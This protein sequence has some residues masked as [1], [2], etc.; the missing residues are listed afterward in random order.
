MLIGG[1]VVK[2][3][4]IKSLSIL[5]AGILMCLIFY[6]GILGLIIGVLGIF[7]IL[8][9]FFISERNNPINPLYVNKS[10]SNKMS[11]EY[12]DS[13]KRGLEKK[14]PANSSK[15]RNWGDRIRRNLQ[16]GLKEKYGDLKTEPSSK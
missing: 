9:L 2:K 5:I 1:A 6:G 13:F 11:Q 4:G 10:S 7:S 15:D 16:A 8:V 12:Q 14:Y 3:G